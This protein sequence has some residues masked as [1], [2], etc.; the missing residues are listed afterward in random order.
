MQ[1]PRGINPE[2]SGSKRSIPPDN[3]RNQKTERDRAS[4]L[5]LTK[6]NK[7][8]QVNEININFS[9]IPFDYFNFGL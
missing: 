1:S 7:Q 4:G 5:D 6:L 8:I 3:Y 9:I 2:I